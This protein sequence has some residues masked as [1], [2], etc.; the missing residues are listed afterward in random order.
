MMFI[1]YPGWSARFVSMQKQCA[2]YAIF[3]CG[4]SNAEC[5]LCFGFY[6]KNRTTAFNTVI[7]QRTLSFHSLVFL[8]LINMLNYEL[9]SLLERVGFFLFVWWNQNSNE[10]HGILPMLFFYLPHFYSLLLLLFAFLFFFASFLNSIEL[11]C[12]ETKNQ[13][14]T[15]IG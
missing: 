3:P 12:I 6:A 11:T 14:R 10:L 9:V 2:F 7:A 1:S 15:A 8:P 5:R 13:T 4:R